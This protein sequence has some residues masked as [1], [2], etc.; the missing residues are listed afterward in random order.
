M[1]ARLHGVDT[2]LVLLPDFTWPSEEFV[3]HYASH[4]PGVHALA[5]F[6]ISVSMV[7]AT[8]AWLQTRSR[9]LLPNKL[10]LWVSDVVADKLISREQGLREYSQRRG[11]ETR[12]VASQVV[13]EEVRPGSLFER[14]C[15][16]QRAS[17]VP[18]GQ[19]Q[20]THVVLE[21]ADPTCSPTCKVVAIVDRGNWDGVCVAL[22]VKEMLVP[23]LSTDVAKVPHVLT[24]EES[25]PPKTRC[26]LIICTNGCF[27]SAPFARQVLE[28]EET[29]VFFIPVVGE[30][31]FHFPTETFYEE[32]RRRAPS[33]LKSQKH[34]RTKEDRTA[35]EFVAAIETIFYEIA[36]EVVL[37]DS[38]DTIALRVK[39][40][41]DRL[42]ELREGTSDRQQASW[43]PGRSQRWEV[44]ESTSSS[45]FTGRSDASTNSLTI[46]EDTTFVV[47]AVDA[48]STN[49][50]PEGS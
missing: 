45:I 43:T 18:G 49:V 31:N 26:A 35:D 2:C 5:R 1:T 37:Q 23:H 39:V 30:G 11:V 9:L 41:A 17:K 6:G 46:M 34:S 44:P 21:L 8:L 28:A 13:P 19:T 25:L 38:E 15:R 50:P 32:V 29:G 24:E 27:H 20:A 48:C 40:I 47:H 3:T 14:L 12:R 42:S 7:Q 22:S 10:S 4:V 36:I 16:R 33:T